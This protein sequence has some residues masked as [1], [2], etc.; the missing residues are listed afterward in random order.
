MLG[1]GEDV[2]AGQAKLTR[3][4]LQY[5]ARSDLDGKALRGLHCRLRGGPWAEFSG[6]II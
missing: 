6:M 3:V 4:N 1:G 5:S 2:E